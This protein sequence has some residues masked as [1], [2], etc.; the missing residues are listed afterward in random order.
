MIEIKIGAAPHSLN[1]NQR[2]LLEL[3]R[4]GKT[5]Y[6]CSR[7]MGIQYSY[8]GSSYPPPCNILDMISDIRAAGYEL[9]KLRR[10][11]NIVGGAAVSQ[12][13]KEDNIVGKHHNDDIKTRARELREQGKTAY[14]IAN[15]L[16]IPVG[17]VKK[18]VYG[19]SAKE[20]PVSE[21]DTGKEEK[22]VL[23]A[24]NSVA[25]SIPQPAEKVKYTFSEF[26]KSAM[27]EAISN[28]MDDIA[29]MREQV[30]RTTKRLA[31]DQKTLE[32]MQAQLAVMQHDYD[33]MC[34]GDPA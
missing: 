28:Y 21:T 2:K 25:D 14:E 22:E 30:D 6:E 16:N 33:V 1:A 32:N 10:N 27:A 9:P 4:G 7:I 20:K 8:G 15:E 11:S 5:P 26:S 13:K 34:G 19:D 29:L 18:W 23:T 12:E 24:D 31:E 3:L 17:T